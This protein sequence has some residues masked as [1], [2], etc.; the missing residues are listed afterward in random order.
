METARVAMSEYIWALA[1]QAM[2]SAALG[3]QQQHVNRILI[4]DRPQV[5]IGCSGKAARRKEPE[6]PQK[7]CAM[8]EM[9]KL[10]GNQSERRASCASG[11]KTFQ[12]CYLR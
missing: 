11:H 8:M 4:Q 7:A 3:K 9:H 12:C 1:A 5:G 6:L 10:G 2:G